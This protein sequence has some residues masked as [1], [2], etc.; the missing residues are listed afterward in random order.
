MSLESD[1]YSITVQPLFT[2]LLKGEKWIGIGD[3]AMKFDDQNGGYNIPL[4]IQ[5]GKIMMAGKQPFKVFI[6]PQYTPAGFTTQDAAKYGVKL[7]VSL[8]L[9]DAKFGYSKEKAEKRQEKRCNRGCVGH[10]HCR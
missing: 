8:L 3:L 2:K 7:S 5:F 4:S 1:I 9:P 6:Q 10:C